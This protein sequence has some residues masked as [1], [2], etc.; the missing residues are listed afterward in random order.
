MNCNDKMALTST[1]IAFTH[2]SFLAR[3]DV[4]ESIAVNF[5]PISIAAY[6][7]DEEGDGKVRSNGK[8]R[9]LSVISDRGQG[10]ASIQDGSIE[11]MVHR[12]LVADDARGVS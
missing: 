11:L 3:Q 9:Q 7:R 6:I 10:V 1:Y 4:H 8:A 5:Y 12:R 2:Y